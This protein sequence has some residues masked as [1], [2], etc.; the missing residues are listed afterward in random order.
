MEGTNENRASFDFV[1]PLHWFPVA[2]DWIVG[3]SLEEDRD[4]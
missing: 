3:L 1:V 4:L 2:T